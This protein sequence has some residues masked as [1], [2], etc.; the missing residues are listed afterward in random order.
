VLRQAVLLIPAPR[1][2]AL[3]SLGRHPLVL[4]IFWMSTSCLNIVVGRL[5][6]HAKNVRNDPNVAV[7]ICVW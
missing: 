6:T 4:R 3:S 1:L 5:A 2:L 7:Y